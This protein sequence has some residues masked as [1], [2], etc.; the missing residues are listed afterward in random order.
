M[1]SQLVELPRLCRDSCRSL[2]VQYILARCVWALQQQRETETQ[3]HKLAQ[4]ITQRAAGLKVQNV[5]G[6]FMRHPTDAPLFL[7]REI[8]ASGKVDFE[9]KHRATRT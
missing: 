4:A 5:K 3:H 8:L 2:A 6:A 1:F 9:S 7:T